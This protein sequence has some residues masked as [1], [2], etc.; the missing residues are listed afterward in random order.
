MLSQTNITQ[1]E[2]K[3]IDENIARLKEGVE[4]WN[5]WR[6]ENRETAIDLRKV[7]LHREILSGADLSRTDFSW[8]DLSFARL[9]R[10]SLS[11]S[12]FSFADL[13]RTDF[14]RA[15]LSEAK[16]ACSELSGAFLLRTSLIGADLTNANLSGACLTNANLTGANLRHANFTESNI[17]GVKWNPREMR[18]KYM[19]IRGID[20]SYGNALF[21]RA[22]TDQDYLDTLENH[23]KGKWQTYLFK[24]W[25]LI[26][27]GRS[28]ERVVAIACF[29]MFLFGLTYSIFPGL[30]GLDCLPGAQGCSRHSWFTPFYFSIVTFT[31]LGFGDITPKNLAGELIVSLEVILG[32]A[33]LGLL[34]SVLAD[35]VVRRS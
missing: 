30:L 22:A 15:N 5:S 3:V 25:G 4:V 17:S 32:Y 13:S 2:Q 12:K 18:G 23:W 14:S 21:K 9:D 8:A 33:V 7:N 29:T 28:I 26:D 6:E 27:Y 16:L 35:K 34:I 1:E 24:L 19:G 20:S 11:D 10:S 31:T